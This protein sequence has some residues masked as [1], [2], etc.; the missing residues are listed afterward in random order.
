MITVLR[1]M[2]AADVALRHATDAKKKTTDTASNAFDDAQNKL[3]LYEKNAH[4]R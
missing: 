1:A 4:P 3:L 2:L